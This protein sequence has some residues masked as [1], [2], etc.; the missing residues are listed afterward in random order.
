MGWYTGR[1]SPN[2]LRLVNEVED[3]LYSSDSYADDLPYWTYDYDKPNLVIPYTLD[4]ND[5]RFATNQ[6]FNSGE[7]FFTYY[8]RDAFDVLYQEGETAPKMMSVGLHCRLVG[9]PGRAAALARFLDYVQQHERGWLCRRLD[10]A[11]HWHQYHPS[12]NR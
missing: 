4:N 2:T 8:L 11:N 12:K 6:G 3:L 10:I 9:R 5:M 1:S 7:Q